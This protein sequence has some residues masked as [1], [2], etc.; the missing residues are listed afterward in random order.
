MEGGKFS[1]CAAWGHAA[2]KR[3]LPRDLFGYGPRVAA[4]VRRLWMEGVSFRP[5]PRGGTRPSSGNWLVISSAAVHGSDGSGW[6]YSPK[7]PLAGT[8]YR[9]CSRPTSTQT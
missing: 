5:A 1:A 8:P 2:F 6:D 7:V 9:A 3:E 4:D